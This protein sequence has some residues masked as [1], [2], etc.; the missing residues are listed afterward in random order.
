MQIFK[1]MEGGKRHW[2][3]PSKCPTEGRTHRWGCGAERPRDSRQGDSRP[4]PH[5]HRWPARFLGA[6]PLLSPS[7]SVGRGLPGAEWWVT[8]AGLSGRPNKGSSPFLPFCIQP[9][10][11]VPN[12]PPRRQP[13]GLSCIPYGR[14]PLIWEGLSRH[15]EK[16]PGGEEAWVQPQ[17]VERPQGAWVGLRVGSCGFRLL[18]KHTISWYL[19]SL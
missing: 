2:P 3:S 13:G 18:G 7:C 1:K 10:P 6:R 19:D 4:P 15:L 12:P 11:L 8:P 9:E 17:P 16:T 14:P 5:P